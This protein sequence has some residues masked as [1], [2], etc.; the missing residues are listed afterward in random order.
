MTIFVNPTY[1]GTMA[2]VP[3]LGLLQAE[4]ADYKFSSSL[5]YRKHRKKAFEA[6]NK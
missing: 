6:S 2:P 4:T 3:N 5:T 1:T